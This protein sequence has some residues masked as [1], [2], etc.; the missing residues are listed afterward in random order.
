MNRENAVINESGHLTLG[1]IDI[2]E[3]TQKYGTPLYVMDQE[4]IENQIEKFKEN[5]QSNQLETNIMYA[6]KA[7]LC[8]GMCQF[9]STKKVYLDVVSGGELYTAISAGFPSE[10]ICL[11]GNNKTPREL[12]EAL[13]AKV[14]MII[15][16]HRQEYSYLSELAA[17]RNQEIEV[18]LRLNPGIDAHT[19][20]YIQT[21][22]HESKFGESIYSDE[23]LEL[24]EKMAADKLVHLKGFHCHIGSQI[25]ESGSFEQA[26]KTM[27]EYLLK[28]KREI[29]FQTT[30]LNLGGGFGIYYA[31]G[32]QPLNLEESLPR[33]MKNIEDFCKENEFKLE[34]VMLEPGRSLVANS[35]VTLYTIGGTK[36]TYGG[37]SYIFVDGG[38]TDNIR[39]ALYQAA[40]EGVIANKMNDKAE[41]EMTVAGKCC[42]SG[43]MLIHN[44]QFPV[45]EKEDILAIFGTGA[46]NYS[47]ASR[48]NRHAVP[49][50]VWVKNGKSQIMIERETYEDLTKNDRN[51]KECE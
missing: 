40:Y 28:I 30:C 18:L 42:E 43:D 32:D 24:I 12:K 1:K 23:T 16:D 5:F 44:G 7:F 38:M 17:K 9:L 8:K 41:H 45:V 19:H 27:M 34:R 15:V 2:L 31:K 11:H 48:Y 26:A 22:K 25:F 14:G 50:V 4:Y 29:G 21:S 33:L 6:S 3:L 46:Y 10:R 36:K 37:K 47:M 39:P 49:A 51:F 13:D 20:E 35:G